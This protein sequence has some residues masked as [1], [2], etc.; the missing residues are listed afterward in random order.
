M[1]GFDFDFHGMYAHLREKENEILEAEQRAV[2]DATDDLKR[3]SEN[4]APIYKSTL[5]K[6]ANKSV[7][8]RK[9][10]DVVG[11]V[12]FSAVE[13]SSGYGRFNYAYWTHEMEYELGPES[14]EASGTDGYEVGNKYLERPLKG[15]SNK[16]LEWAAEELEKVMDGR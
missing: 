4:I 14:A 11:E 9:N 3:I 13:N 8:V 10:G 5:R 1:N 12:T 15:E 6:S 2:D 7:K 16:Y